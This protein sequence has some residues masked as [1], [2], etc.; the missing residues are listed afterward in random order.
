MPLTAQA[1][2]GGAGGCGTGDS[3]AAAGPHGAAS[4]DMSSGG[5]S[6][7]LSTDGN[8]ITVELTAA[9]AFRGFLFRMEDV[10]V[11]DF[12]G[13]IAQEASVCSAPVV[14]VTHTSR[15]DKTSTSAT[16]T[17]PGPGTFDLEVTVVE[18][19]PTHFYER[20]SVTIEAPP[21]D[22]DAPVAA[23]VDPATE[24]PVQPPVAPPVEASVEAPVDP[25]VAAPVDPP[26]AVPVDPPV[27]PPVSP[28]LALKEPEEQVKQADGSASKGGK[29]SKGGKG[30]KK[31]ES[32]KGGKG[33][34]RS[35]S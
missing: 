29:R 20:F 31:S 28:P 34:K 9:S 35:R 22:T 5:Y 18:S 3:A 7:D 17:A 23:P 27:E 13:A 10:Q 25:P 12:E 15:A 8:D 26:V 24:A 4:G 16:F 30:G 2:P 14:G 33:G 19:F 32:G 21:P 11:S 6:V 1:F